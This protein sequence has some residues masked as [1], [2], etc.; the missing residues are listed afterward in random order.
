MLCVPFLRKENQVFFRES[1]A[2]PPRA[3]IVSAH[4]STAARVSSSS[5]P[6]TSA[7]MP[8]TPEGH[9]GTLSP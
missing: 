2:V 3:G 7:R 4:A 1:Y 6:F 8:A 5:N 9:A